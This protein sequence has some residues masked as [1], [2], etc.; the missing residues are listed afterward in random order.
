MLTFVAIVLVLIVVPLCM[1]ASKQTR[2]GKRH[3][4]FVSKMKPS[5]FVEKLNE[6]P[7]V[8]SPSERLPKLLRSQRSLLHGRRSRIRHK[9]TLFL[10]RRSPRRQVRP[11][12]LRMRLL[13][14]VTCIRVSV[15]M[16]LVIAPRIMRLCMIT[17]QRPLL[18][19]VTILVPPTVAI[20]RL[21]TAAV[22]RPAMTPVPVRRPL[23][24]AV[25][26]VVAA[27]NRK[28]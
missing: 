11:A 24:M 4:S 1:A 28:G 12:A 5:D 13:I 2:Q 27:T 23:V 6:R 17:P 7:H 10:P 19:L 15:A 14:P 9:P 8:S 26:A 3:E 20:R 22:P 16:I 18:P 25:A 21:T